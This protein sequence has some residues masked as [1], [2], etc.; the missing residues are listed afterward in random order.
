MLRV[1][2]Y[3]TDRYFSLYI[4]SWRKNTFPKTAKG[5]SLTSIHTILATTLVLHCR[6]N[7]TAF[8]NEHYL[9]NKLIILKIKIVLQQPVGK[10]QKKHIIY[11][12]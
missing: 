4:F 10:S 5:I 12:R 6:V 2:L 8:E 11:K 7:C 3:Q 1:H 9:F